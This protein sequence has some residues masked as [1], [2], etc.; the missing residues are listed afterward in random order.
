MT[1]ELIDPV[2]SKVEAKLNR[3]LSHSRGILG[4]LLAFLI[5]SF[6]FMSALFIRYLVKP[7]PLPEL[8]QPNSVTN[9]KPHYLFS[10]Y[11]MEKPV[12]VGLSPNGERL[13]VSESAGER[14]V[15]I[16]DRQGNLLSSF[17][18]IG[19]T[20]ANRSPVYLAVN[21]YGQV[22][23]AD[24]FHHAIIIYDKDGNQIDEVDKLGQDLWAPLGVRFDRDNTLFVTDVTNGKNC[25][26]RIESLSTQP[27]IIQAGMSRYISF[28][29][30]GTADGELYFPN[31][32]MPDSQNR[33]YISDGNNWRISVWDFNGNFLYH[34]GQGTSE[35]G[36]SLPR[37]MFVDH[38]DRL[39]IADAVAHKIKVF[40]VSG[41]KP[42]YLFAFGELGIEDGFFQFPNDIVVAEE[43]RLYIA[44]RENNRVQVWSY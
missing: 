39:Y 38:K 7:A 14:K 5:G 33:I 19:S 43:G 10:I 2:M 32:A 16:F 20:P 27:P 29:H 42:T 4:I 25:F 9:Y 12:G 8:I 22:Y 35:M 6:I 21:N 36:V 30:S 23:V 13:Y 11:G 24:R 26:Y 3:N 28:G 1:Q 34:F 44:D 37:G 18:P 40:D 31:I 17:A 15:Y 41:E